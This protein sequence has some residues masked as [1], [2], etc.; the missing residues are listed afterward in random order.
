L[1]IVATL[2][3][4]DQLTTQLLQQL[5]QSQKPASASD[6][7]Q[8]AP[9]L[10]TTSLTANPAPSSFE[11]KL[12]GSWTAQ[13]STGTTITVSFQDKG[14]FL[15]KVSRQGKDQQFAGNSSYENGLLTLIQ[16]QN[17]NTMVGHVTW[18][19]ETHFIFKVI[20]AGADDPGLSFVKSA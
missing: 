16:D 18:K 11:G 14:Q 3:P 10:A 5:E 1:K 2:Q 4:K 6:T 13:P 19:D 15:W 17:N 8:T 12:E 20:G 9:P 7:A